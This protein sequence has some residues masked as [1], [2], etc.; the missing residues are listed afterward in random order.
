MSFQ[1]PIFKMFGPSPLSPMQA[2]MEKA[3]EC[4]KTLNPFFKAAM[5][6]NWDE[7]ATVF[8]TIVNL[9]HEA[10]KLKKDLRLHLPNNLFLPV[11]RNDLLTMIML[12]DR[13]ANKAKDIAGLFLGR[14]MVLP[15]LL[16]PGFNKFFNRSL[17][18][19]KQALKAIEELD[20]LLETG[21]RGLEAK[22]VET[23]ITELDKIEHDTDTMQRELRLE[24]FKVEKQL[25]PVDVIFYYKAI[26]WTG[27]LADRAQAVGGQLELLLAK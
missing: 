25:P 15:E 13:V 27:D 20:E 24:L 26:E 18:A 19:A 21:F 10:D 16:Q 8:E 9:E 22:L 3:F 5:A 2:H 7:A 12:Q 4:A 6:Q 14:Q 23:M 17:D 1:S 11:A